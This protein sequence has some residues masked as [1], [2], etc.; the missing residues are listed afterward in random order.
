[1]ACAAQ[2]LTFIPPTGCEIPDVGNTSI[3]VPDPDTNRFHEF[4]SIFRIWTGTGNDADVSR[5]V[6]V[7]TTYSDL[8]E[9]VLDHFSSS[10]VYGR[11]TDNWRYT[12]VLNSVIRAIAVHVPHLFTMTR[13][14]DSR[15]RYSNTIAYIYHGVYVPRRA[16][17]P[18][19]HVYM[20]TDRFNVTNNTVSHHWDAIREVFA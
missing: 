16:S 6:N 18:H 9:F 19:C 14:W 7:F 13:V 8:C 5:V 1:M 4:S 17:V 11:T 20:N 10:Y 2:A 3:I 15:L 12:A